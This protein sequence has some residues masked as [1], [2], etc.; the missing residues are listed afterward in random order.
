MGEEGGKRK[1]DG[2]K[3]ERARKVEERELGFGK[4]S[5]SI[6]TLGPKTNGEG[7][8][9]CTFLSSHYRNFYEYRGKMQYLDHHSNFLICI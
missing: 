4:I 2:G 3:R 1:R 8:Y 7:V 6:L 9:V 5:E